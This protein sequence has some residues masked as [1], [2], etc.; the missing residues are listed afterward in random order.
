MKVRTSKHARQRAEQR[1]AELYE[2]TR[3]GNETMSDWLSRMARTAI[4]EGHVFGEETCTRKLIEF[5]EMVL[6]LDQFEHS[7]RVVTTW[8]GRGLSEKLL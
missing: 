7:F 1:H 4:N 2:R 5:N 3:V 6:V 8:P